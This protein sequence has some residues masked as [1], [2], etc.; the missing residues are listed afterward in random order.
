MNAFR[1]PKLQLSHFDGSEPLDWLFQAE[2]FFSYHQIPIEARLSMV[3]FYM[4]GD[5]LSWFKWM[6]H[7]QQLSDW[8]AFERALELRFGPTGYENFRA[9]LFKLR[10]HT[11]V[12][13]YQQRFEKISNRVFGLP[14]DAIVDCFYSGLLPEIQR[15]VAI[16]KPTTISQAIGLS[17]LIEAKIRDSEPKIPLNRLPPL[18]PPP[19]ITTSPLPIKRLSPTQLQERRAQGLCFNCDAKYHPGHKCQPPK[20]LLLMTDDPAPDT[21][22]LSHTPCPLTDAPHTATPLLSFDTG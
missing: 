16:L 8:H 13:E 3:A 5:A 17:K 6:L 19:D 11:T 22:T 20:F 2:Q 14:P 15:E 21:Q 4:K 7:N 12:T 9:E 1:P 18:P 10:Q